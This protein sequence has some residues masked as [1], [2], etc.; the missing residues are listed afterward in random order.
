LDA[1]VRMFASSASF[2]TQDLCHPPT[3]GFGKVA[4]WALIFTALAELQENEQSPSSCGFTLVQ[5][6]PTC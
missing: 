2:I 1:G 4:E 3:L 6:F 5:K